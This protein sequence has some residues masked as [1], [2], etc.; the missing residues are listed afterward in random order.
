[1]Q[2]FD[3]KSPDTALAADLMKTCSRFY[4]AVTGQN[5]V[6]LPAASVELL[7]KIADVSGVPLSSLKREIESFINTILLVPSVRDSRVG[8]ELKF[9][10]RQFHTKMTADNVREWVKYGQK[11]FTDTGM[12]EKFKRIMLEEQLATE[13]DFRDVQA[14]GRSKELS[15]L[16]SQ[17]KK[18]VQN[19][20]TQAADEIVQA[21]DKLGYSDK[22][23]QGRLSAAEQALVRETWAFRQRASD[24][25]VRITD[26]ATATKQYQQMDVEQREDFASFTRQY[27]GALALSETDKSKK[28]EDFTTKWYAKARDAKTVGLSEERFLMAW[29]VTKNIKSLKDR[30]GKTIP[31]SSSLLMMEAIYAIPGLSDKQREYLFEARGVGDKAM[32]TRNGKGKIKNPAKVKEE[33]E[34]MRKEAGGK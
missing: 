4:G 9:S 29:T 6:A 20:N 3:R 5:N 28:L 12:M 14:G 24:H 22:K 32:R 16:V 34:K 8:Q 15:D 17:W 23:V 13:Q 11:N 10:F 33:L 2:G 31:N 21:M 30:E 19:G 26:K 18:E 25:N 1:M 27:V 7:A